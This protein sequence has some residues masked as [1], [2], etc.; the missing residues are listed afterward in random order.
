[1]A[2]HLA[3]R[4]DALLWTRQFRHLLR[5]RVKR[6]RDNRRASVRITRDDRERAHDT[7][8]GPCRAIAWT[9]ELRPREPSRTRGVERCDGISGLVAVSDSVQRMRS[10]QW[11]AAWE[12]ADER[13]APQAVSPGVQV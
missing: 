1:V 3:N 8:F 6:W 5:L 7:T 4:L 11:V 9:G 10:E 2:L 12:P 13:P